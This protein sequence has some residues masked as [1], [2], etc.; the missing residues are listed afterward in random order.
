M[1]SESDQDRAGL[2]AEFAL[3]TLDAAETEQA[4]ALYA[5]NADFAR[6]V[7]AWRE[8]LAALSDE[9]AAVEP[10]DHV[11]PAVM[12]RIGNAARDNVV[13]FR[14]R[15]QLTV[16]RGATLAVAG[17]AAALLV[18]VALP[19]FR[20]TP[21]QNFIAVLE[22]DGKTPAFVAVVDVEHRTIGIRRVGAPAAD[23]HS[24]EL[25]ALG[26][27]RPAPQSLGVVD[28]V[29]RIPIEK[30]NGGAALHDTSFAISLEPEGGSPTGAP[31]GPVLFVGKLIPTQ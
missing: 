8:K 17:L 12:A 26:G 14:L 6:D 31:T 22:A 13:V 7:D 21:Q 27:G 3:G 30:L 25:W 16:W 20:A 11:L 9:T 4:K 15:R 29:A 19:M 23:G 24:Y 5:S 28:A 2:A 18:F 10:P 1:A